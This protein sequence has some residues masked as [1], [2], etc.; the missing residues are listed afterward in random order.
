MIEGKLTREGIRQMCLMEGKKD[1]SINASLNR[2]L[3]DKGETKTVK[4]FLQQSSN[5]GFHNKIQ[6]EISN[7]IPD[8]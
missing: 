4:E 6:D 5:K 2:M 8:F 1:S 3:T 7:I